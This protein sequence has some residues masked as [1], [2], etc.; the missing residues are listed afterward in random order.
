MD[1]QPIGNSTTCGIHPI[2]LMILCYICWWPIAGLILLVEGLGARNP[3]VIF[4]GWQAVII[5]FIWTNI[6]M[7]PCWIGDAVIGALLG[8]GGFFTAAG[9]LAYMLIACILVALSFPGTLREEE[10]ICVPGF[11]HLARKAASMFSVRN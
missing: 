3:C 10:S 7:I 11:G 4:H 1:C 5:S 6:V 2:F 9:F 8:F